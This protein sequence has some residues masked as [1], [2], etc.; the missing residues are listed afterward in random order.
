MVKQWKKSLDSDDVQA[1]AEDA[2][3]K[4]I[5]QMSP[6]SNSVAANLDGGVSATDWLA[7][8]PESAHVAAGNT[9]SVSGSGVLLS[10]AVPTGNA[11]DVVQ[12]RSSDTPALE[13][14]GVEL[15][16]NFDN[17]YF[18]VYSQSPTF[19]YWPFNSS[20]KIGPY[21]GKTYGVNITYLLD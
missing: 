9:F 2:L 19:F 20:L 17:G 13:I 12:F 18:Y 8:T 3:E 1:E 14:D 7:K 11:D 6:A 5:S 4:D 10:L 21:S 15:T 16:T